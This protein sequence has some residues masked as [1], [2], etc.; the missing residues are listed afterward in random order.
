MP[1]LFALP[2]LLTALAAPGPS[3]PRVVGPRTSEKQVVTYR[4]RSTERGVAARRLR[5]QCAV[6]AGRLRGCRSPYRTRLS[7]GPH[8]LRVRALDPRGRTSP[9][10]KIRIRIL[11]PRA[12]EI[13]VGSAPLDAIAVGDSLWTENYGDGTVSVIDTAARRVTTTITVGGQPGGIAYGAGSVWVSDLGGG[14]LSRIDLA[15]HVVAR[16][17]VGSRGCRDEPRA[18]SHAARGQP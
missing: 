2:L 15:G 1:T 12:P 4:F 9:L 7:V 18:R 16:I 6:D 5:F 3:R 17:A 10:S 14:P 8:V 13:R 11:E